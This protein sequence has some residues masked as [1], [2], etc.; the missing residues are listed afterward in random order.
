MFCRSAY[1][2][3]AYYLTLLMFGVFG[4]VLSLFSFVAVFFPSNDQTEHFFQRHIHR[5]FVFFH[6]W[7]RTLRLVYVNYVG[8]D[9]F[10]AG[11]FVLAA[12]HPALIDITCLL[13]RMPEAL[14]I[15][16]PAIRRNPIL[17][18]AARS[19]G[20]LASDGGHELLRRAAPKVAAGH[21][22]IMFPEGTRT[23]PGNPLHP[24]KSGFAIIARRAKVP[25]Q[26]VRIVTDSDVLTKGRAWWKLPKFP[27]HI[28][29]KAGPLIPTDTSASIPELTVEIETW[30]RTGTSE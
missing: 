9:R 15:F 4:L 14:C 24:F 19:A 18:A 30:F 7:C 26:L 28:E 22:L 1:H 13:A 27:A 20:Y 23:I 17:G 2:L 25:V 10:P 21:I 16:K 3:I 12:N 8:F 5:N 29:V 6:W 11:G